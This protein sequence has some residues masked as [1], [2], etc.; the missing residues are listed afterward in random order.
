MLARCGGRLALAVELSE[1]SRARGSKRKGGVHE[2]LELWH[3]AFETDG[4]GPEPRAHRLLLEAMSRGDGEGEDE[5]LRRMYVEKV[6]AVDLDAEAVPV[7]VRWFRERLKAGE[8]MDAWV[9]A[10]GQACTKRRSREAM[11][12]APGVLRAL[13]EREETLALAIKLLAGGHDAPTTR[14]AVLAR[15]EAL[16]VALEEQAWR[17]RRTAR[18]TRDNARTA[19]ERPPGAG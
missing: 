2:V 8:P 10:L 14:E 19:D 13:C 18:M 16:D 17:R 6:A 3:E 5:R 9:S 7:L 11:S 1:R 4:G 12:G 15:A